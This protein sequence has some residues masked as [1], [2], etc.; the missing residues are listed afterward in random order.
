MTL[1]SCCI[2]VTASFCGVSMYLAL[3]N[4][5]LV[6]PRFRRQHR[7]PGVVAVALDHQLGLAAVDASLLA[8]LIDPQRFAVARLLAMSGH[9]TQQAWIDPIKI[10]IL[11]TP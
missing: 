6:D 9:R 7:P 5:V 2:G 4:L 8:G 11:L 10:S 3:K 1:V